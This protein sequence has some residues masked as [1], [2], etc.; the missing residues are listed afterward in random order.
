MT[1][2]QISRANSDFEFSLIAHSRRIGKKL[3]T[4]PEGRYLDPKVARAWAAWLDAVQADPAQNI[5]HSVK[6]A[7]A[8]WADTVLTDEEITDTAARCDSV[9]GDKMYLWLARAVL[10]LAGERIFVA[11]TGA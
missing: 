11:K 9:L 8:E 3:E 5:T 1:K 7:A 4:D 10:G 2:E 6:V